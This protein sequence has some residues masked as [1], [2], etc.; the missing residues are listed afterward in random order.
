M[1]HTLNK[2]DTV[3]DYAD[4]NLRILS[5]ACTDVSLFSFTTIIGTPV[6]IVSAN[7]VSCHQWNCQNVFENLAKEKKYTLN[8]EKLLY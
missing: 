6:E 1:S 7:N 2:Y 4:K 3:F 8:T 5:G